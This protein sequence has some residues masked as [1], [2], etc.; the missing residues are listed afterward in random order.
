[1]C[2]GNICRSPMA[3]AVARGLIGEAGL[4]DR[5]AVESYGTAG[6]HIG[7]RVDPRAEAAL[8]RR[9]WTAAPHRA[10]QLSIDDVKA[11][12]LLL[13]ADRSNLHAVARL[14]ASRSG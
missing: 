6:Y 5:V 11:A 4:G 7:E 8:R 14:A 1:M 2:L 13:C 12:D 3:A 10:R 9:V